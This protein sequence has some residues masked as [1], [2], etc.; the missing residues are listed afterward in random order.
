MQDSKPLIISA[1]VAMTESRVI[2]KN[3]QLPWHLPAD[4]KHF[5]AITT[6]HAILMGR[7]T[8]ASIGKPLPHRTNLIMTRDPLFQA[9]GGL[10]MYNIQA[11]IHWATNN[12]IEKIF[13]IGGAEMYQQWLPYIQRIYMTIVHAQFE[14][15]TYFPELQDNEWKEIKRETHPADTANPYA[16]SLLVLDKNQIYAKSRE[17]QN[18]S[19]ESR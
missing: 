3:N 11:A 5:K 9:T 16:Y 1:I 6:G 7:K 17:N 4:L 2:G 8:F 15:D 12:N 14:G 19:L 13:I 18:H 10:V